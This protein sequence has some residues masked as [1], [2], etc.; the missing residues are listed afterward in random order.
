LRFSIS[1]LFSISGLIPFIGNI[2]LPVFVLPDFIDS[3]LDYSKSLSDFIVF[4][5]LFVVKVIGKFNKVVDFC[6]L[7]VLLLLGGSGP[8]WSLRFLGFFALGIGCCFLGA[9]ELAEVILAKLLRSGSIS[10]L[11]GLWLLKLHLD[12]IVWLLLVF[13][14]CLHLSDFSSLLFCLLFKLLILDFLFHLD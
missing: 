13:L 5:I 3:I 11:R 4:H 6:L 7:C 2:F 9:S 12:F 1:F 8:S 10:S 14:G